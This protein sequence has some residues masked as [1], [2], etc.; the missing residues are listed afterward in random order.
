MTVGYVR[1]EIGDNIAIYKGRRYW[2]IQM[3]GQDSIEGFSKNDCEYLMYDGLFGAIMALI[4][5]Q[6]NGKFKGSL[7]SHVELWYLFDSMEEAIKK[8]PI[9]AENYYKSI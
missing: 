7:M 1:P 9:C 6:E 8:L 2:V 5:K 4:H 3:T